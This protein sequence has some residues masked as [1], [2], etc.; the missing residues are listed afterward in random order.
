MYR[1]RAYL[2][3]K[4]GAEFSWKRHSLSTYRR[5][6]LHRQHILFIT[7]IKAFQPS[8]TR[9]NYAQKYINFHVK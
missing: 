5:K 3:P 1:T 9:E 6:T 4:N 7:K 2:Q 8:K